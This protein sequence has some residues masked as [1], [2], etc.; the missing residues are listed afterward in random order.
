MDVLSFSFCVAS[1][2]FHRNLLTNCDNNNSGDLSTETT[3]ES[4]LTFSGIQKSCQYFSVSIC[5]FSREF[6]VRFNIGSQD[7]LF[8]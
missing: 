1:S 8:F 6:L 5:K 4:S 2:F 3:I 7:A